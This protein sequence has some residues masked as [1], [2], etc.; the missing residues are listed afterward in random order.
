MNARILHIGVLDKSGQVHAIT[1]HDGVNVVT[2]R[3]STGKS[4]LIE[5]FDYCFGSSD[6]TVPVGVITDCASVYFTVMKVNESALVLARR[7]NDT[8]AFLREEL[9]LQRVAQADK[10]DAAY[11]EEDYFSP[12]QA[13]LKELKRHFGV[14]VTDVDEDSTARGWRGAKSATPSARSFTSYMLQHQNLVANKHAIFYRFDQKEKREQ[15]IDHLK[16]FLG[17]AD[18]EYFMKTQELNTLMQE[19]RTLERALP[20]REEMKETA[21]MRLVN[22]LREYEA[23]SGRALKLD[24]ESATTRPRPAIQM[25]RETKIEVLP[26]SNAHVR[27]RQEAED[28]ERKL[29]ARLRLQQQELASVESSIEFSR[30]YAERNRDT[31]V[32]ESAVLHASVCP[33]CNSQNDAVE[34]QANELTDAINWLNSELARSSY[35]L[36]SFEEQRKK[37]QREIDT[38]RQELV[39]CRRQITAIEQQINDLDNIRSQ[40]ELTVEAKIRVENTLSELAELQGKQHDADLETVKARIAELRADLKANYDIHT[41]MAN[42]EVR[43]Q[44]LLAEFGGRFDFEESYTPIKLHFSLETFDLWHETQAGKKVY[45]RSMGSGAN[46]LSCH[47]VL[48][49]ALQRYFCEVGNG[50]SIPPVLFF[51]QP[52]QVYFPSI[53]DGGTEFSAEE[54][55]KSDTSRDRSRPVDDDV[56]AVTNLFYQLVT[57]CQETN[58]ATGIM[59]QIIVTDHA[60]HLELPGTVT[61][62]SLVRKRWRQDGDGFIDL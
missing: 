19:Q 35:R 7:S 6:F 1:F 61:F 34:E 16:I 14:V 15:A 4:A 27:L 50:C 12:L 45:L 21:K 31:N 57:Y 51:D 48:F 24:I 58:K 29:V 60:D 5:I 10:L 32:P 44:E 49:L 23:I 56:K 30:R 28:E 11:F 39:E 20:R 46:W 41:K 33:F 43:I 38:T 22:A 53:L 18:Q 2:G 13:F 26:D 47:L 54:L 42:A 36:E 40:Y 55:A 59:P 3:S 62:E 17:F 37:L 52:S 9:D 25:L 8:Q